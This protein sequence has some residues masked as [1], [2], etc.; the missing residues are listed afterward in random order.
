MTTTY[1]RLLADLGATFR[2]Q[3][4]WVEGRGLYLIAGHFASGVGAGA[5]V[6]GA[7][8]DYRPVLVLA[9]AAVALG[10]VFH[11][12]FLGRPGRF[13]K[14]FRVRSSWIARGFV[15]MNLFLPAAVLYL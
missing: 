8:F 4:Q 9:I 3:R 5:W 10:G 11:L 15:G 12:A 14:M 7:W 2:P 1:D 6:F 13:W